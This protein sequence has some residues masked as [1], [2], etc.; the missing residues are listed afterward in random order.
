LVSDT[1]LPAKVTPWGEDVKRV[2]D[3][4]GASYVLFDVTEYRKYRKSDFGVKLYELY[5]R[6]KDDSVLQSNPSARIKF[7]GEYINLNANMWYDLCKTVGSVKRIETQGL[8]NSYEWE[9]YTDDEKIEAVTELYKNMSKS[10]GSVTIAKEDF[11]ENNSGQLI[12]LFREQHK[13][14]TIDLDKIGY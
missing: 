6:T 14:K 13:D 10:N 2:P 4:R 1:G 8:V 7:G 5:K 3:G 12:D 9:T 11:I